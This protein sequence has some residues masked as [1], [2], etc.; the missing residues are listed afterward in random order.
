MSTFSQLSTFRGKSAHTVVR[1]FYR[2]IE[3]HKNLRAI[4]QKWQLHNLFAMCEDLPYYHKVDKAAS[5]GERCM[6]EGTS[7]VNTQK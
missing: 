6:P 4:I 1:Y 5:E 7:R 2:T 3:S